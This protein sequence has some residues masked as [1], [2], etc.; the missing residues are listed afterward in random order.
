MDLDLEYKLERQ[1]LLGDNKI[2]IRELDLG[3]KVEHP[4]AGSLPLRLA[5]ALLTDTNG[6]IDI[7]LP[8]RGDLNDPQ[9]KISGIVWRAL[10]NLITKA[11]T[12]PFRF[13]GSLI[14]VDSEDFGTL[15]FAAGSSELTPPDREQLTKLGE[16]MRQRPELALKVSGVVAPEADRNAL[17][18]QRL[19]AQLEERR[20]ALAADGQAGVDLT[21]Q[22]LE[23]VYGETV[24]GADLASLQL[25]HTAP[26]ATEGE[27]G[28]LDEPAYLAE[29]RERLLAAQV[30]TDQELAALAKAR[31]AAVTEAMATSEA[32]TPLSLSQGETAEV[33]P[34]DGGEIP[35]ELAVEA[36]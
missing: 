24:A 5:V 8:V 27:A 19:D 14:G 34:D 31:A 3:E 11:V 28:V 4:D 18:V 36:E 29:L 32:E 21:R 13:L 30:I 26:P 10:G 16:A 33:E 9:F 15:R 25:Q 6:V 23:A 35:L 1:Q 12:A 2:V 17:Q 20:A 7:D 22:A